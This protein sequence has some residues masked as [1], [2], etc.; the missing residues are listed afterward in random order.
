MKQK[1]KK[2]K[3]KI[4]LPLFLIFFKHTYGNIHVVN[5]SFTASFTL[6]C[7]W[8]TALTSPESP[9]SPNITFQIHI[10][11]LYYPPMLTTAPDYY[12]RTP[13]TDPA[14]CQDISLLLPAADTLVLSY[15]IAEI[16]TLWHFQDFF[17]LS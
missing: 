9:T 10:D 5:P 2:R 7:A 13:R 6:C 15:S 11:C 1:K 3:R 8:V 14:Y 12:P 17:P 16:P 4:F